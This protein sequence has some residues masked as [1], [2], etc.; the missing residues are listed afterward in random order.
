MCVY[1]RY[2]LENH[3][4]DRA[5]TC[6]VVVK[7]HGQCPRTIAVFVRPLLHPSPAKAMGNWWVNTKRALRLKCS[8]YGSDKERYCCLSINSKLL[9][10]FPSN[11]VPGGSFIRGTLWTGCRN[12]ISGAGTISPLTFQNRPTMSR[13]KINGRTKNQKITARTKPSDQS[14]QWRAT[15]LVYYIFWELRIYM[16]VYAIDSKTTE[17]IEP[18]LAM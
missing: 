15:L 13:I 10:G 17:S 4:I 9:D 14:R 1:V 11:F 7:S 2:R 6:Y 18:K 3:W 16:C 5:Q 8:L 12:T